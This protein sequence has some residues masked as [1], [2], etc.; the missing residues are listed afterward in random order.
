[1]YDAADRTPPAEE[2]EFFSIADLARAVRKRL[3]LVILVPILAA[4]VAVGAS[5]LK[6]PVYEAAATVVVGPRE[7]N[8]QENLSTKI[9]G[10]QV[11]AHEMAVLGLNRSMVEGVANA[12]RTGGVS[13]S[14]VSENLTVAQVEDTRFLSLVY[15]DADG[16]TAQAVANGAA[17]VFAREAPEA[18]G[19]ASDAALTVSAYAPE[20]MALEGPDP[21][22]N[23]LL[24]LALGLMGGVGLAFLLERSETARAG[25]GKKPAR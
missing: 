18:S 7:A 1:M 23:G 5:L 15:Q 25:R 9:S 10:L 14:D 4:G 22:R 8:P 11:L 17:G 19:M 16:D 12:P 13:E 6:P 2:R 24:A 3:W 21:A 20:P